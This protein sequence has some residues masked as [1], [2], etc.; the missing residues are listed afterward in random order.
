M[1]VN[2]LSLLNTPLINGNVLETFKIYDISIE[3][4]QMMIESMSSVDM[5]PGRFFISNLS[6]ALWK[7]MIDLFSETEIWTLDE[8][9]NTVNVKIAEPN[10]NSYRFYPE[11]FIVDSDF[12]TKK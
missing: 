4:L 9:D 1:E 5:V 6:W 7:K 3:Q 11:L 10:L 12:C 2:L 8:T